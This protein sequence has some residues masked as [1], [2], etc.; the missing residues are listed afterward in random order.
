MHI[1]T[2]S[3]H[4]NTTVIFATS[5]PVRVQKT[6]VDRDS[7]APSSQDHFGDKA[8]QGLGTRFDAS[9]LRDDEKN[10]AIKREMSM[11]HS[12][13]KDAFEKNN[14]SDTVLPKPQ[15]SETWR[16]VTCVS[17]GLCLLNFAFDCAEQLIL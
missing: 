12:K 4:L 17:S 1:A 15:N 16:C 3:T 14:V 2:E 13:Q 8:L 6:D 9:L 5:E 11:M 7:R 10:L